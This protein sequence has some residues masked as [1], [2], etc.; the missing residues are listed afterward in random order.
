M[1]Y[2]KHLFFWD[3]SHVRRRAAL[4]P[5]P[6]EKPSLFPDPAHVTTTPLE[7]IARNRLQHSQRQARSLDHQRQYQRHDSVK[8]YREFDNVE[9][10]F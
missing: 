5:E 3:E 8:Y 6:S 2:V 10:I 4:S 9:S 7:S 1:G